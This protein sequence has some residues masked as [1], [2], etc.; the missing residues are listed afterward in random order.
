[1]NQY[2]GDIDKL[3]TALLFWAFVWFFIGYFAG[4]GEER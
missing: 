4:K 2:C 1:M 3:I